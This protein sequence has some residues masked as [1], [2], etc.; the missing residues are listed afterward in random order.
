ML[1]GMP[2]A[3]TQDAQSTLGKP[4]RQ[5]ARN[6]PVESVAAFQPGDPLAKAR[7][8]SAKFLKHAGIS[9]ATVRRLRDAVPDIKG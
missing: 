3:V 8:E 4:W 9:K 2:R 6:S 7:W 1:A 5:G